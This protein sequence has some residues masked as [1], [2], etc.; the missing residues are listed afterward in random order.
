MYDSQ[1]FDINRTNL[2]YMS[3]EDLVQFT[4]IDHLLDG[5]TLYQLFAN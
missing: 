5:N 3:D 4:K 2:F 1:E